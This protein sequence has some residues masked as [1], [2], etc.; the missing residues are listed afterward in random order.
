MLRVGE[1]QANLDF[2]EKHFGWAQEDS[3]RF[4][5]EQGRKDCASTEEVESAK[6]HRSENAM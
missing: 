2:L 1:N 6:A 4:L 5:G 3:S